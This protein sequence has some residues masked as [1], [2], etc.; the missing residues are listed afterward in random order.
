MK[1]KIKFSL[2]ATLLLSSLIISNK[3]N[4][5][6]A[7][8]ISSKDLEIIEDLFDEKHLQEYGYLEHFLA[9]YELNSEL[10]LMYGDGLA[11]DLYYPTYTSSRV[12]LEDILHDTLFDNYFDLDYNFKG[13]LD[14]NMQEFNYERMLFPEGNFFV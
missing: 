3:S 6:N 10:N 12:Q 11:S 7:S 8:S 2:F 1:N 14:L 13:N 9:N 5:V 4:V